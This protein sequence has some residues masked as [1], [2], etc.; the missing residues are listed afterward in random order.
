M[1]KK[2]QTAVEMSI[3]VTF[4][5]AIFIVFVLV[6]ADHLVEAANNADRQLLEDVTEL[7]EQ[8]VELASVVENGYK[9]EFKLPAT[10]SGIAYNISLKYHPDVN[11]TEITGMLVNYTLDFESVRVTPR[12]V[13]GS[14]RKN[15]NN[16]TKFNDTVWL[17][18]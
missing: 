7:V 14:L 12:R 11:H 16:I 18:S 9:R 15:L 13:Q 6:L 5:F 4:L 8:E 1:L 17:N 2:A 3:V 10:L